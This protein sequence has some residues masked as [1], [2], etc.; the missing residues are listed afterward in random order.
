MIN[1]E[2]N[3][4]VPYMYGTRCGGRSTVPRILEDV[5]LHV[6]VAISDSSTCSHKPSLRIIP[7]PPTAH[8]PVPARNFSSNDCF[9]CAASGPLG[10]SLCSVHPVSLA[11]S[12]PSPLKR[13]SMCPSSTVHPIQTDRTNDRAA[14]TARTALLRRS[15]NRSTLGLGIRAS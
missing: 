7:S 13:L 10:A 8:I 4:T 2:Q 6:H 12:R 11:R 5:D 9:V 14:Y 3:C 1:D 15:S